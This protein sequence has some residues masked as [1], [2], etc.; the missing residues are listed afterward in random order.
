MDFTAIAVVFILFGLPVT[1]IL[2]ALGMLLTWNLRR[3]E[4]D[5]RRV[6][7][8]AALAGVGSLPP[9]LDSQDPEALADWKLVQ[10]ELN[11]VAS[12]AA[13]SRSG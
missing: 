12:R 7:A 10:R 5:V 8:Q 11:S 9:W 4:L 3:R 6:E 2:A 1:A 13:V